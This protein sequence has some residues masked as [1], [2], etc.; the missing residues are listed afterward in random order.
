[1]KVYFTGKPQN[2]KIT[3]GM[4]AE[5]A[6]FYA[7][8]LMSDKLVRKL[9]VHIVFDQKLGTN[10]IGTSAAVVTAL[11]DN[12]PRNFEIGISPKL[13]LKPTLRT[14]AHEMVHV[15]QSATGRRYTYVRN[16]DLVRWEKDKFSEAD[17]DYWSLPW[18]IE[19]HGKEAGLYAKYKAMIDDKRKRKTT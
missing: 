16:D 19:A 8:L 18:E 6:K 1:M 2:K 15:E 13:G 3:K 12:Y 4:L 17:N 5:A 10:I 14:L 9:Q 7:K 11:S